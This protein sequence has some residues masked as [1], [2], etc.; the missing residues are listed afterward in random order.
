MIR[1]SFNVTTRGKPIHRKSEITGGTELY[2]RDKIKEINTTDNNKTT[3]EKLRSEAKLKMKE[4]TD[5]LKGEIEFDIPKSRNGR[6]LS[7][8]VYAKS[9]HDEEYAEGCNDGINGVSTAQPT[10]QTLFMAKMK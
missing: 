1:E 2:K 3:I 5:V 4:Y 9:P 7:A 8:F 6:R 10:A